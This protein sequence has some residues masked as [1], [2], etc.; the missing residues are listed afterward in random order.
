MPWTETTR[1]QYRR[2]GL[3]HAS[4]LTDAEWALIEPFMPKPAAVGRPRSTVLRQVVE[5]LLYMAATGCQGRQPPKEFP[6]FQTVQD[7]FYAGS[8]MGCGRRSTMRSSWRR[9]SAKAVRP[10]RAPGS[11]IASL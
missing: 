8:R 5:A 2:D 3:R 4:D 6:P 10:A 9:A 11:S 7:Y 1:R